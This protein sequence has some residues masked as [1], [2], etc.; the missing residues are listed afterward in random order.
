M[1]EEGEEKEPGVLWTRMIN[2]MANLATKSR[3][4]FNQ[5]ATINGI[6]N[7]STTTTST[8]SGSS[9][10][11]QRFS[12]SS[13]P[14]EDSILAWVSVLSIRVIKT[15]HLMAFGASD[16]V[17]FE[18]RNLIRTYKQLHEQ[19]WE[20]VSRCI[21]MLHH[22]ELFNA[23]IFSTK[24][25]KYY[26]VR[27]SWQWLLRRIRGEFR[28]HPELFGQFERTIGTYYWPS[29][30]RCEICYSAP[31]G[32]EDLLSCV[33]CG[34]SVHRQCVGYDTK[35]RASFQ[36][37]VCQFLSQGGDPR[38]LKCCYCTVLDGYLA[39]TNASAPV[40]AH[41][42]CAMFSPGGEIHNF[43]TVTPSPPGLRPQYN[44]LCM[45]NPLGTASGMEDSYLRDY[46]NVVP[47]LTLFYSKAMLTSP[48]FPITTNPT[49]K[50]PNSTNLLDESNGTGN[51]AGSG[52]GGH[53][54][55]MTS[56]NTL[57][58]SSKGSTFAIRNTFHKVHPYY[59]ENS[60]EGQLVS[61]FKSVVCSRQK[62]SY[63][64]IES[65]IPPDIRDY[66]KQCGLCSGGYREPLEYN[67]SRD[68]AM[69]GGLCCYCHIPR[70]VTIHCC[71]P[72]CCESFHFMCHWRNG[73]YCEC[74]NDDV[75]IGGGRHPSP[76]TY[77]FQHAPTPRGSLLVGEVLTRCAMRTFF[78]GNPDTLK[79]IFDHIMKRSS[80]E[81]THYHTF[82]VCD[83]CGFGIY[84]PAINCEMV[85]EGSRFGRQVNVSQTPESVIVS[86]LTTSGNDV[87]SLIE[88]GFQKF[89]SAQQRLASGNSV[90]LQ[91]GSRGPLLKCVGCG[92]AV[93]ESCM[94]L[95]HVQVLAQDDTF[96]YYL[97]TACLLGSD[98]LEKQVT[99]FLRSVPA[100]HVPTPHACCAVCGVRSGFLV[101]TVDGLLVHKKCGLLL[102][103]SI[104][105]THRSQLATDLNPYLRSPTIEE[106]TLV[107]FVLPS[108]DC[109]GLLSN[110]HSHG[111]N[112]MQ[113]YECHGTTGRFVKCSITN[114]TNYVHL[115]CLSRRTSFYYKFVDNL[116]LL[117][118]DH[119]PFSLV[120]DP[121]SLI[122]VPSTFLPPLYIAYQKL[123][124]LRSARSD[125]GVVTTKLQQ[126]HE[127]LQKDFE[128]ISD[129]LNRKQ[130]KMRHCYHFTQSGAIV[131]VEKWFLQSWAREKEGIRIIAPVF[132]AINQEIASFIPHD[133]S[134]KRHS[135]P[136]MSESES[137]EFVDETEED[138]DDGADDYSESEGR[139]ARLVTRSALK[140]MQIAKDDML[141]TTKRNSRS[142]RQVYINVTR[143][144]DFIRSE[145]QSVENDPFI[146]YLGRIPSELFVSGAGIERAVDASKRLQ[147]YRPPNE[148][149]KKDS[150][151][152]GQ[153][154]ASGVSGKGKSTKGKKKKERK[155]TSPTFGIS[156]DR[157]TTMYD[158]IFNAVPSETPTTFNKVS[159]V[160]NTAVS[161][162]ITSH[163]NIQY[164]EFRPFSPSNI[165]GI[166]FSSLMKT[167]NSRPSR[168]STIPADF[169]FS[170][171][172]PT[173]SQAIAKF[174]GILSHINEGNF[175]TIERFFATIISNNLQFHLEDR[176]F[177]TPN[178]SSISN[179][180]LFQ[181]LF[182]SS[183]KRLQ[184]L[185]AHAMLMFL[186][187]L[188]E[189]SGDNA[190]LQKA[191]EGQLEREEDWIRLLQQNIP[192]I[193]QIFDNY[194][195]I[196]PMLHAYYESIPMELS[197]FPQ[198]NKDV[199]RHV[200]K[201][202]LNR[203]VEEERACLLCGNKKSAI[204]E[205]SQNT[206]F[207]CSCCSYL[208]GSRL[209]GIW[210]DLFKESRWITCQVIAFDPVSH[211]HLLESSNGTYENIVL[212][213]WLWVVR[214]RADVIAE[215]AY[216]KAAQ[217]Q[218]AE[219]EIATR[220]QRPTESKREEFCKMCGK[221]GDTDLRACHCCGD[222]YHTSC[223]QYQSQPF[224]DGKW[225][226][227]ECSRRSAILELET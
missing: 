89:Q 59:V 61:I 81:N 23:I 40:F 211:R 126:E 56:G 115:G 77:C 178:I 8:G 91:R 201:K 71:F 146:R 42:L 185:R 96:L 25:T 134:P 129:E 216:H 19:N 150:K 90:Y 5:G 87:P 16:P 102:R 156:D 177:R 132:R 36:C 149:T 95:G 191:A 169:D 53:T 30:N 197:V 2:E 109:M 159:E 158:E 9:T 74:R 44:G 165:Q 22:E 168:P 176:L 130:K 124:M 111:E 48:L 112:V 120:Q 65:S 121:I 194:R 49:E 220:P 6:S 186:R 157:S 148:S 139:S 153:E 18:I 105:S 37:D 28:F 11:T 210:I 164:W 198:S 20:K 108:E 73:G 131:S 179:E 69:P 180:P 199:V 226:C 135:A 92:V 212:M 82:D 78:R 4:Q 217:I 206:D 128:T 79:T 97:C 99:S 144:Q 190:V 143:L 12:T 51:N 145:G 24:L 195:E 224:P 187:Q 223:L 140:K 162:E 27:Q 50:T 34:I 182:P 63:S 17:S 171:S 47:Q 209:L 66:G 106:R 200:T 114:C 119:L 136:T 104:Y 215:V 103:G 80:N 10:G 160:E 3:I 58:S 202:L 183:K 64:V 189:V 101:L 38:F 88:Q 13:Y 21:Q 55:S 116:E 1:G 208:Y 46:A 123:Q 161:K 138:G 35:S 110:G 214:T 15:D 163:A 29:L 167:S 85:L 152:A 192:E 7:V 172:S 203:T 222:G 227:E 170:I 142:S 133:P 39:R 155:I 67:E 218:Y 196:G 107:Q 26:S 31:V 84:A 60:H 83:V 221:E 33:T 54:I 14:M 166:S 219:E 45:L 173:I 100:S 181:V 93:H 213:D 52:T 193:Q 125:F 137:E 113:C 75:Y 86:N 122:W 184:I 141:I 147:G 68:L 175:S 225:F 188:F 151:K 70:G 154:K 62:Q 98:G 118:P 205:A 94:D 207:I 127:R 32:L 57:S 117:C 72:E 41:I 204:L 76:H 43:V 174:G